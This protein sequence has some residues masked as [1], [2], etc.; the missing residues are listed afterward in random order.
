MQF[1]K[2]KNCTIVQYNLEIMQAKLYGCLRLR[3]FTEANK[4]I[5][6]AKCQSICK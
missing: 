5:N 1:Q 3:M 6:L 4:L 2:D